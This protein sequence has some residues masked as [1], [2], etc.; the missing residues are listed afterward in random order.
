MATLQDYFKLHFIVFIWSFTVILGKLITI[1]AVELVFYR[2]LLTGLLLG[3]YLWFFKRGFLSMPSKDMFKLLLTGAIVA[4]HWILFFASVKVSNITVC[5]VGLSTASFWTSLI[6]PLINKGKVKWYEIVLG[7]MIIAGLYVIF[8]FGLRSEYVLGLIMGILSA[9]LAALFSTLNSRFTNRYEPQ[10][11]TTYEMLGAAGSILLFFPFYMLYFAENQSLDMTF[12]TLASWQSSEWVAYLPLP[13]DL[14]FIAILVGICTIYAY[15]A[16]VELLRRIPV[17]MTNLTINLE[18]IYGIILA[19]LFFD[20]GKE[21]SLQFFIGTAIILLS[22][23]SY[24][25]IRH[26]EKKREARALIKFEK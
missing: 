8:Q 11:I 18:P 7:L 4:G 3:A 2:S 20:E 21:L 5:L 6:E 24:P 23:F 1:P 9:L 19:I 25:L 26:Y 12:K 17:F 16:S 10:S 14:F 13:T 22:V 15:S